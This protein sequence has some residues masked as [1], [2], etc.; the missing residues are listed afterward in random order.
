VGRDGR[1]LLKVK[2]T[3][4]VDGV[5]REYV[6]TYGR[7]GADNATVG[8]AYASAGTPGGG[9]EDAK[10]IAALVKALTGREPKVYRMKCS[11]LVI[12]C[13]S[14][15]LENFKRYKELVGAIARWLAREDPNGQGAEDTHQEERSDSVARSA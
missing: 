12:V 13:G 3:A 4:E 7:R 1:W 2:I 8:R 11:R 5:L 14:A 6:M 10:R 15:H 9:Q